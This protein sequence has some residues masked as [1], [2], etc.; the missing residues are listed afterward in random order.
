MTTDQ[1]IRQRVS[2]IAGKKSTTKLSIQAVPQPVQKSGSPLV[3]F[4]VVCI[5]VLSIITAAGLFYK[6]QIGVAPLVNS[7]SS[8][9]EQSSSSVPVPNY[10]TREEMQDALAKL[11]QRFDSTD[12]QLANLSHRSWL[13]AVVGNENTNLQ[14][15]L[16]RERGIADPGFIY[17]DD[18]W[19]LNRLPQTMEMDEQQ[20]RDLQKDVR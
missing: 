12:R 19:K 16:N 2:E 13:L 18:E 17:F 9:I 3:T 4:L 20:R 5:F 6:S 10:V 7:Q 8:Q 1:I 15:R 11:N 14:L